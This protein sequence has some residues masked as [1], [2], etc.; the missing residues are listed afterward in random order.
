VAEQLA[1]LANRIAASDAMIERIN[2]ALPDGAKWMAGAEM[3]ARGLQGFNDGTGSIPRI[4]QQM[5]LPAFKYSGHH[6]YTWP[7]S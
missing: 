4:T 6:P 2:G 3:V 1:D 7:R 5:R